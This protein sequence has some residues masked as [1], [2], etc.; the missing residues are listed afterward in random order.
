MPDRRQTLP[1]GFR[2]RGAR[3]LRPHLRRHDLLRPR[4]RDLRRPRRHPRAG[5][6][7][8][9]S[10]ATS[11]TRSA[12][13]TTCSTSRSTPTAATPCRSAASRARSRSRTACRSA[14]PP[15]Y[16]A[17]RRRPRLRRA[18]RRRRRAATATSRVSA[19]PTSTRRSR[20]PAWLQRRLVMAGMRPISLMVDVT[21][22]VMLAV[23]QPTARVRPREA[24]AARSSYAGPAPGR[25]C[26]PSTASTATLDPRDLVITD[27]SGPIALAGVMG[28]AV[29]RDH[30]R[31]PATCCSRRRTSSRRRVAYTARRHRL[32]SEAS[33]R[34]ERGVDDDLAAAAAEL[35]VSLLA[36]LGAA[37]RTGAVTD[38]DQRDA[39]AGRSRSTRR[40]RAGSPASTTRTRPSSR[41]LTEVGCTVDEPTPARSTLTPPSWRPDLRHPGRPGRGGRA[42]RGL[43]RPAVDRCRAPRRARGLTR[44]QRLRRHGRAR[45]SPA[46]GY[47]EVL[48]SPFVDAD[49]AERLHARAGRSAGCRRCGSRTRSPTPSRTFARRCCPGCSLRWRATSAAG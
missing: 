31:R 41:R 46:A 35:A 17:R 28:G 16:S 38:V 39:A 2:D 15:R 49:S 5:S 36:E 6:G 27:D 47:T 24:V 20:R 3:G 9:R 32:G 34:F 48:C 12:C 26:G 45:P 13:A 7:D 29:D 42:A 22:Y 4:A 19:R 43:R 40:C 23:G 10:A 11:S 30:R 1:G 37:R 25:S 33:R 8:C 14:T 21:N 44:P 18:D